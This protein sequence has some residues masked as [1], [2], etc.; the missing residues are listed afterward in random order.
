MVRGT[1]AT[2]ATLSLGAA[3]LHAQEQLEIVSPGN[4]QLVRPTDG[5]DQ[6]VGRAI[7]KGQSDGRRP[8]L[9]Q[10]RIFDAALPVL[11][12]D[13]SRSAGRPVPDEGG[14]A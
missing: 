14:G 12:S 2:L 7:P 8:V 6:D 9:T 5:D 4:G 13:S 3:I 1:V 11:V 10:R